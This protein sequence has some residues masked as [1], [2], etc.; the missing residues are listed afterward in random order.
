MKHILIVDD[1]KANLASARVVL[2]D[3]YKIT[4]VTM[5]S[6]A[7]KFLENNTCDLILLDINMPEMDG[8]EVLE[9]IRQ[10]EKC[11]MLPIIFLTADNDPETENRCLEAGA[12]DFIAKP[13][14]ASVMR[15]R[16]GRIL[17]L[18]DMRR[19]LADK[20]EQKIREVTD[21]KSKSQ[22]DALTGLWN[23]AYTE[24]AV[25]DII[26]KGEHGALFM[27][28]M[29][30]FKAI[31][32]N[33]GHIE[34]DN[35][36]KMFADTMRKFSKEGDVLCRIGG[37]EFVMFVKGAASKAEI[38]N[39][40]GDVIS[41][42]CYKIEEKKY[43]TNSS[44]SIGIAQVPDDGS[45]FT[46]IYNA[47]DKAL[48]YVKQNGKNSY[49]FFSEQREN[50]Q[51]RA[52]NL[53]DLKYLREVM[54]RADS[55]KGAYQ[56]ELDSFHHVYNFIRRFVERSGRDVQT[57]LFT[58]NTDGKSVVEQ[59]ETDIALEMMEL[60]IYKSLRRVDV[61]TR[62]SSKQIIVILMDANEDNGKLVANRIIDCFNKLYTNKKIFFEYGIAQMDKLDLD[63]ASLR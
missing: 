6:Q 7:L 63:I 57:L 24:A 61:S 44:V 48:Y 9:K 5:G 47:A 3:T 28:D 20:L 41:D 56:L 10:I 51:N 49:H 37:D 31:N 33:Y 35:T 19:K 52:G 54:S 27:I 50:E 11:E 36:L 53:V 8:F 34:G 17:E 59:E 30:N 32:D 60:A 42:L 38:G 45:D 26:S 18:E 14:V 40:A 1:N 15:L 25:N 16:I 55:G 2:S 62:Y 23:R 4:A 39:L 21:I 58:L 12:L 43:E 46:T 29:D 13:F 22:Q